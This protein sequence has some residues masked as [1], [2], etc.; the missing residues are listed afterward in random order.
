MTQTTEGSLLGGKIR[1]WQFKS[2]HRTGFEPVL[3]ASC[4]NARAG[5]LVL[6]AGTG[7]GAALL[8]LG[9]RVSGITGIGI[10]IDENLAKL[11]NKNFRINDLKHI[12]CVTADAA[13]P[14]FPA[15]F[16]H[17]MGNPPWF[18]P[19]GTSSPDAARARAH[20]APAGLLKAWITNLTHCLKPRGS[21]TLILPAASLSAA[22]S[23][24]SA[25]AHGG[26]TIIPLW[27]RAGQPAK[28][29]IITARRA[30]RAADQLLP[31]LIL[32]DE[33]GITAPAQAILQDGSSFSFAT[34]RETPRNAGRFHPAP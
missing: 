16:D 28:M 1:Y 17:I 4:V 32:H 21:L 30:S 11:A 22:A 23:A 20:H 10:E 27:P 14:P 9:H 34:G 7:A 13:Q 8:C 6:E 33:A 5:E 24:L 25:N 26:I 15:I 29:I 12:S 19:A 2:G 3:L 31:G 18:D